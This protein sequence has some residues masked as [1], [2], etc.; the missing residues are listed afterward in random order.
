MFHSCEKT[1]LVI[2]SISNHTLIIQVFATLLQ[3]TD[4]KSLNDIGMT[5]NIFEII[6][7]IVFR[8]LAITMF[9]F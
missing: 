4:N 8:A 9:Y 3:N 1:Y 6:I 2:K 5:T 7:F